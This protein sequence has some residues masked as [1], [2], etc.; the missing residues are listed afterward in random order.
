MAGKT[1]SSEQIGIGRVFTKQV[2]ISRLT[3]GLYLFQLIDGDQIATKK[4]IK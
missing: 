1:I 3:S 4:F 2:D